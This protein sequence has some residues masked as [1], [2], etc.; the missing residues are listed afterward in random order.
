MT[1]TIVH[2]LNETAWREFVDQ[3]PQGNIFHTPEMQQVFAR[4]KGHRTEVHAVVDGGGQI[5]ALLPLVQV[6]LRGDPLRRLT[7]RAI[8]YGSAL[9]A[10]GAAGQQALDALLEDYTRSAGRASVFTELRNLVDMSE[11]QPVLARHGFQYEEHLDY[12]IDLRRAPEEIMKSFGSHLRRHI[13]ANE[14]KQL[15][16]VEQVTDRAG[17]QGVYDLLVKTYTAARVPVAD[18]SLF[19]AAFDV[20]TPRK[21]VRFCLAKAGE[22]PIATSVELIY[23]DTL[24]GWYGGV[25]REY[26]NLNPNEV[27]TWHVLRWGA[28]NGYR[29]Y[30]FGGA[31]KPDEKYGVRDFKS[32]FGGELVCFGRNTFVPNPALLRVSAAGYGLLRRLQGR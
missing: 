3:H 4:V 13:R 28:E 11:H 30:D 8:A 17:I 22:T 10:P 5:L 27:L 32:K 15:V 21:M 23:K 7:T 12:L 9:A 1:L 19:E 31:G 25:D 2:T 16:S 24:Y 14:K 29:V 18:C 20:L 26:S 6:T